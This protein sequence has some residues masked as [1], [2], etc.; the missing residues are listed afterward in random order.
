MAG[1]AQEG[2]PRGS[3]E[4]GAAPKVLIVVAP[5][6]LGVAEAL[7]RGA[8]TEIEAWGATHETAE[9]PGALEIAPAVAMASRV[10]GFDAFVA[11]GCV[12]RGETSHYETVCAESAHGLTL[13]GLQGVPVGNGIL[14]VNEESQAWARARVEEGDKGGDAARA[15]LVMLRHRRALARTSKV[16]RSNVKRR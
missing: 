1:Q 10:G 14:T 13:I 11:L 9:V 4:D 6:Y 2:L 3:F 16:K 15:A 5:Y 7:L 12:I 8:R